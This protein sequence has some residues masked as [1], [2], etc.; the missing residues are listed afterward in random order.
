V[1]ARWYAED[2]AMAVEEFV[3]CGIA[4]AIVFA[5]AGV[6]YI[7]AAWFVR[8]MFWTRE[9]LTSEMHRA[10][11]KKREHPPKAKAQAKAPEALP[12]KRESE[13]IKDEWGPRIRGRLF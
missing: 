4:A 13:T 12:Y 2:G 9:Q 5:F 11:K 6:T 7:C 1:I 3:L 10:A 8:R